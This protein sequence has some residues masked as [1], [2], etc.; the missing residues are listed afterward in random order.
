MKKQKYLKT[1]MGVTTGTYMRSGDG[2]PERKMKIL[3]EDA[4][5]RNFGTKED[6]HY[7]K[8]EEV[9]AEEFE[10]MILAKKEEL[11][12][13]KKQERKAKLLEEIAK[14]EKEIS[15]LD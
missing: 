10:K 11:L 15:E 5:V 13:K 6:E 14:L 7:Y 9:E 8:V 12:A 4:I 1:W 2:Y 3:D